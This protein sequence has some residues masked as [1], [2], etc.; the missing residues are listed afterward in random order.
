MAF[1]LVA[2]LDCLTYPVDLHIHQQSEKGFDP[3]FTRRTFGESVGRAGGEHPEN[4]PIAAATLHGGGRVNLFKCNLGKGKV[5]D[6]HGNSPMVQ[7]MPPASRKPMKIENG[8]NTFSSDTTIANIGD[9][10]CVVRAR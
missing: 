6:R 7:V 8:I 4:H 3:R 1:E 9:A 10:S 5:G 2:L